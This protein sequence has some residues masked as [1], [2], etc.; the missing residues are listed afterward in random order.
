L[1]A[2]FPS[3]VRVAVQKATGADVGNGAA[4]AGVASKS[5]RE[6]SSII[7]GIRQSVYPPSMRPSQY[8]V[9]SDHAN[10]DPLSALC[11]MS[12]VP[13]P[14]RVPSPLSFY[15]SG[16]GAPFWTSIALFGIGQ[17]APSPPPPDGSLHVTPV[18]L[19]EVELPPPPDDEPVPPCVLD[20]PPPP[21]DVE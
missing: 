11:H 18:E 13:G 7:S 14:G 1:H 12:P 3:A 6:A 15:C 21:S 2:S 19:L 17:S 10:G 4:K 16:F 20:G 9:A 8:G 5:T